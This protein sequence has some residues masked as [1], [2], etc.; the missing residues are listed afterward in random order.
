MVVVGDA[1]TGFGGDR[2]TL[3]GLQREE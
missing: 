2:E 1:S 3:L